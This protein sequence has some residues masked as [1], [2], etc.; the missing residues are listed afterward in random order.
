[1]RWC[2]YLMYPS[3]IDEHADVDAGVGDSDDYEDPE[4][5]YVQNWL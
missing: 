1:M 4:A 3:L 2:C 5:A